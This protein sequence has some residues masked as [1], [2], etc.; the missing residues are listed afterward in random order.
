M[1][2]RSAARY[3][4][5]F[6][7]SAIP[8]KIA[9]E[10]TDFDSL[11]YM[12][13]KTARRLDRSL[14]YSVAA[15]RL[16]SE[17]SGIDFSTFDPDR[18]GVVEGTSLSNNESAHK[19]EE[20]IAKRGYR[21]ISP[22]ALINGYC[23]GG[24]GE[25]AYE[26]GIKGHAITVCAGSA[27]GNDAIGYAF[28]MVR[29]D[30]VDL[31]VAG[32]AEAPLLPSVMGGFSFNRV[33]TRRND[34]PPQ[35]M[36]PFDRDR[37]GF[38]LGEG[39]AFLVLEEL[40]HALYRNARIYA[41][42]LGHGRSC[43]AYHP[44]TPHPEGLGIHRAMQKAMRQARLDVGAIDYVNAHG[45]ATESNDLVETRAIKRLFGG[46]SGRIAVSSTKPVT[47][48][49]MAAAGALETVVCVLSLVNGEIPMT[50]NL[51]NPDEGFDLDYVRGESR[52]YP[53]RNVMN[54]NTGFGGKNSCLV[55]GR[56]DGNG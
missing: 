43:E 53:V 26:L 30:E 46:H 51:A 11:R 23:G 28:N 22:S 14:Q 42:I 36:R 19:T 31:M 24:S 16:A 20:A 39:G 41:E 52:H 7:V 37:D 15:A 56:F 47:G 6:D 44:V 48:H 35:A 54:L 10:I 2:G 55:L 49:L 40:S 3:V 27:S 17:D 32:G 29:N 18:V 9:A 12:N 38:L 45:T 33:M 50:L 25:I 4:T 1:E 21:A 34:P 8:T 13:P 5:R